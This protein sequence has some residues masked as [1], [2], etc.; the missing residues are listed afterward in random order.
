MADVVLPV[1][2]WAEE[3]GTTTNL[4]GRVL[5]RRQALAPPPGVRSDLEVMKLIATALNRGEFISDVPEVAFEELTRASSGGK[6][7]YGG[8]SY[9]RI[10]A[11]NGLFWP[12]KTAAEP[13][14]PRLF[15]ERFSTPDGRARFYAVEYR[16][17]AEEPN[18]QF[19]LYLTTGRLLVQY[20]SGAQTRRIR[21]LNDVE[22]EAFVELHPDTASSL[23]IADGEKIRVVTRRGYVTC[24][25]R[26]SRAIRFDTLFMPFHFA[27]EGR[28]NTLTGNAVDP[29]SKIPEFKIAAAR[30]ERI[31]E[32][33]G[34]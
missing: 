8:M 24:K 11:D 1:T 29:V 12:C 28:A 20:Q 33:I 6:A 7:D 21:S 13:G 2:Q 17:P 16:P 9:A 4:E 15:A 30:L 22:P 3:E 25:A 10:K 5:Y 23:N 14:T 19:P 18:D 32:T 31:S 27:G 34:N 26:F